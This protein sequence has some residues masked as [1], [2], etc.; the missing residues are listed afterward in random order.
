MDE[1]HHWT[2][3]SGL[4]FGDEYEIVIV[5]VNG[6]GEET[7]SDPKRVQVGVKPGESRWSFSK[8]VFL[9]CYATA[10]LLEVVI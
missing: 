7:R 2:N 6:A 5:A 4:D 8:S 9:I 1:D 10:N 3:I